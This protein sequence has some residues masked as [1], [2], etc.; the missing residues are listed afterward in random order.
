[1]DTSTLGDRLYRD[2]ER[3]WAA[4]VAGI[5]A[6]LGVGYL[7]FPRLVYDRFIWQ[8]FW[9]PVAADGQGAACAARS[10]GTIEYLQGTQACAEA[11][12]A[13]QIVAYP[14]YTPVSSIGYISILL[15]ALAGVYLLLKRL[16]IGTDRRFFYALFPF[17]L[18]GGALRTVE[19]AGVSAVRAGAEPLVAFPY[20]ALII[21][22]FIYVL[23]FLLTLACVL[24]AYAAAERGLVERYDYALFGLGSVI[25]VLTVGYLGFLA[26]TTEFTEF[27]VQV[28]VVTLGIATAAAGGT[29]WLIERYAP[30]I[31]AGTGWMGF[32]IIW[33]HAVDGVANV[34]GLN[35][36]PAL[37]AGANLVPKH[38]INA[39]IVEYTGRYL[40]EAI[41]AVTGDAW[42][43]LF[44]KLAAA[45]FVVWI[46][47][48]EVMEESPRFS[49]LLLVTVLAV[50]L[51]PGTR[52]MLR[53]TFGV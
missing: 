12:A 44:V 8:Y 15:I 28:L 5:V 38:P 25:V 2:P 26:V 29:W 21:S 45:T 16:D 10:D 3:I 32:V 17:V 13:S 6:V 52:D 1:M 14:G 27:H 42:P 30:G 49:I 19:D 11:D 37:G 23:V 46:F 35:W 33:G 20:S 31:N 41:V 34:I 39:A 36:M 22:P 24:A 48:P 47:E 51:G 9:G 50:G 18:F 7:L 53:A 40:P 4:T 43:F